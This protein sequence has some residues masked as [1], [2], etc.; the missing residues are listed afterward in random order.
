GPLFL[1]SRL[2]R[3]AER[4]QADAAAAL[5]DAGLALQPGQQPL[6][7][8]LDMRGPLSVGEAVEA[9]GVS[10][11]AVTRSLT[12]LV[13]QGLVERVPG[14]GD[15]RTKRLALTPAGRAAMDEAKRTVWPYI[16]LAAEALCEGL[17][18]P[19]IEQVTA[20]EARLAEAPLDR[21]V[22]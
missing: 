10:Q 17:D 2:K 3:L 7:A 19:L 6:L 18:G 4:M 5:R 8:A 15:A 20:L 1:G 13:A 9:L 11:P 22:A 16:G 12:A 14:S 21:T